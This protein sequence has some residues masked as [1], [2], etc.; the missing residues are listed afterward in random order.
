MSC[1]TWVAIA[2]Q[3]LA[4]P[5]P[6]ISKLDGEGIQQEQQQG[7]QDWEIEWDFVHRRTGL[8]RVYR[9]LNL[10]LTLHRPEGVH[11]P[12]TSSLDYDMDDSA[13]ASTVIHVIETVWPDLQGGRGQYPRTFSWSAVLAHDSIG[14]SCL[15]EQGRTH[16]VLYRLDEETAL[17]LHAPIF[18]E[19]VWRTEPGSITYIVCKWVRKRITLSLFLEQLG[20]LQACATSH[21][22]TIQVDNGP[23]NPSVLVFEYGSFARLDGYRLI[24]PELQDLPDAGSDEIEVASPDLTSDSLSDPDQDIYSEADPEMFDADLEMF[25]ADLELDTVSSIYRPVQ[26]AGRAPSLHCAAPALMAAMTTQIHETWEDLGSVDWF[27]QNVHPSYRVFYSV[28]LGF[29]TRVLIAQNDFTPPQVVILAAVTWQGSP[30][31]RAVVLRSPTSRLSC[32]LAVGLQQVCPVSDRV[33]CEVILNG[34]TLQ[35]LHSHHVQHGD[36]L[37]IN[38]RILEDNSALTDLMARATA[39]QGNLQDGL[40]YVRGEALL[41]LSM[42]TPVADMQL[43]LDVDVEGN[44]SGSVQHLGFDLSSLSPS[45]SHGKVAMPAAFQPARASPGCSA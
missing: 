10:R 7:R 25:D 36:F 43:G 45:M 26:Q 3:L 27:I 8:P 42:S 12:A 40:E 38:V 2:F 16:A 18:L 29:Y 21:K 34:R 5:W 30:I 17:P 11:D 23:V 20:Y 32:I 31:V 15:L 19:V 22:C 13:T 28:G 33:H 1:A 41:R 6:T 14:E 44:S 39:G 37:W 24:T 4:C 9:H 35:G